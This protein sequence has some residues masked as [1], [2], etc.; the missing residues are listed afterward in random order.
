MH[1]RAVARIG[2]ESIQH[3][4]TSDPGD[5]IGAILV[6]AR[7]PIKRAVLVTQ[8]EMD[9]GKRMRGDVTVAGKLYQFLEEFPGFRLAPGLCVGSPQ[10]AQDRRRTL[11]ARRRLLQ[12]VDGFLMLARLEVGSA[13]LPLAP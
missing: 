6:L 7:E 9:P 11:R 5:R 10:G 13:K 3:V 4:P 8:S 12:D 2:A 1:H